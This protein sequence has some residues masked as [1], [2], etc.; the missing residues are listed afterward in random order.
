MKKQTKKTEKALEKEYLEIFAPHPLPYQGLYTDDDSLEQP[1][2][3]KVF[4]TTATPGISVDAT[5][6][7]R[8]HAELE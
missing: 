5:P 4:P 3:L 8:R 1:S 6:Y 7:M 2:P